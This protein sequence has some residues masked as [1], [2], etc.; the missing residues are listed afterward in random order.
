[1][2]VRARYIRINPNPFETPQR[3]SVHI[4]AELADA[5]LAEAEALANSACP[6]GFALRELCEV[7]DGVERPFRTG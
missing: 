6:D 5:E 4:D 2:L 3:N 7:D 1:M